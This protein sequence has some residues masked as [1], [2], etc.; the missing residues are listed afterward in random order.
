MHKLETNNDFN[1]E[2]Q[3]KRGNYTDRFLKKEQQENDEQI[4][5]KQILD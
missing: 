1:A 2:K 4:L 3:E 5:K